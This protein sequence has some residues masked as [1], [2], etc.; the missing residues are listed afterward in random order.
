MIGFQKRGTN[1]TG[2]NRE[3]MGPWDSGGEFVDVHSYNGGYLR[4]R[5]APVSLDE[6]SAADT[7]PGNL[8]LILVT[9][10]ERH[11]LQ[12]GCSKRV[13]NSSNFIRIIRAIRS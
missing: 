4:I 1:G 10:G 13:S 2:S 3:V 5:N 7:V 6:Y 11:V 12:K 9:Q 8:A